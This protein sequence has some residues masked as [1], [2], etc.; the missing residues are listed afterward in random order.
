MPVEPTVQLSTPA[1]MVYSP[2][3]QGNLVVAQEPTIR[4][5]TRAA[6]MNSLSDQG[7][8]VVPQ[9]PTVRL[10][11]PAAVVYSPS[12]QGNLVVAQEPTIH[13]S[14]PAAMVHW[15]LEVVWHV[16]NRLSTM[17]RFL[18]RRSRFSMIC[19]TNYLFKKTLSVFNQQFL[20]RRFISSTYPLFAVDFTFFRI[21]LPI[22]LIINFRLCPVQLFVIRWV[23]S[24]SNIAFD[25]E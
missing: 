10:S 4:L 18:C 11:T 3:D 6:M 25:V 9:E 20:L 2:S 23:F 7:N 1:A 13:G 5:S 21:P 15:H 14:T 19:S 22:L 16:E 17:W 24:W 12:D 8:L